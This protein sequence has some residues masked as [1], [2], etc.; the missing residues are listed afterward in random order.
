MKHLLSATLV[1]TLAA[2]TAFAAQTTASKPVTFHSAL[3]TEYSRYSALENNDDGSNL[4]DSAQLFN[5]AK[6][7]LKGQTPEPL[8]LNE[9]NYNAE[10]YR[11]LQAARAEVVRLR[12]Q[13]VQQNH[14]KQMAKLQ[15]AYDCTAVQWNERYQPHN[16]TNCKR[17]YITALSQLPSATAK[18]QKVEQ[19]AQQK[20]TQQ[21]IAAAPVKAREVTL[22]FGFDEA[23]LGALETTELRAQLAT[24][25]KEEIKQIQVSGHADTVGS[26]TYNMELSKKRALNV[27]QIIAGDIGESTAMRL[28][29]YGE[30]RLLEP[31][32]DNVKSAQNRAVKVQFILKQS[33][34]LASSR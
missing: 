30:N 19:V 20:T 34:Q 4:D 16:L 22:N 14:P 32:R 5:Q 3:K 11:W 29:A 23:E 18:Q 21:P 2:G 6:Q 31:T 13:N 1:T 27:A 7:A 10:D 9:R 25:N 8:T 17:D 33:D 24:L 12:D 28:A 15:A 26:A